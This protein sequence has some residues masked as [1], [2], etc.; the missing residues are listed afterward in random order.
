MFPKYSLT[1]SLGDFM[2]YSKFCELWDVFVIESME[3]NPINNQ[4]SG[5][6]ARFFLVKDAAEI[7]YNEYTKIKK[8]FKEMYFTKPD[9]ETKRCS[10]DRYKRASLLCYS[11]NN[12]SPIYDSKLAKENLEFEA[13]FVNQFH[14]FY[15]GLCSL[16]LDYSPDAIQNIVD[17]NNSIFF[18]FPTVQLPIYEHADHSFTRNDYLSNVCRDL[19]FSKVFGNYSV[20]TLANVFLLLE[21]NHCELKRADLLA[22]GT[23][24]CCK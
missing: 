21:Y 5:G 13:F 6:S 8:T 7:V 14:A 3:R 23:S 10:I 9:K 24:P 1:A 17:N 12:I 22:N 19:Y 15:F 16:L 20:L 11:F 18:T 2:T 4:P